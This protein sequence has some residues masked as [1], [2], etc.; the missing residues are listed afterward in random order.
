MTCQRVVFNFILDF[1][2]LVS[3]FPQHFSEFSV[4]RGFFWVRHQRQ[5]LGSHRCT[6]SAPKFPKKATC[7]KKLLIRYSSMVAWV[8]F[9]FLI[10]SL[11]L[12]RLASHS[13]TWSAPIFHPPSPTKKV[14]CAP[15]TV[16]CDQASKCEY[17]CDTKQ[18][19]DFTLFFWKFWQNLLFP[20]PICGFLDPALIDPLRFLYSVALPSPT[21]SSSTTIRIKIVSRN[22]SRELNNTQ[23]VQYKELV[24]ELTTEVS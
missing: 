8:Y 6:W 11:D 16:G 7:A 1:F 2:A 4:F 24:T 14:T 23:S 19:K 18:L 9:P 10:H 20:V 17:V 15:F 5:E 12:T 21:N 3:K 22:Y 13:R